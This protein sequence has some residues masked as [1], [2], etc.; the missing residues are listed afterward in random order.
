MSC[1]R[2]KTVFFFCRQLEE[3]EDTLSSTTKKQSVPVRN[4]V[5]KTTLCARFRYNEGTANEVDVV[6]VRIWCQIKRVIRN[7]D[8]PE[9]WKYVS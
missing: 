7:A 9:K 2:I 8:V 4:S 3:G 1:T 5:A 6:I